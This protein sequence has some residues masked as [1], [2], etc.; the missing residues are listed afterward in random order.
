MLKTVEV[1][2]IHKETPGMYVET[3]AYYTADDVRV[4]ISGEEVT[5]FI[6]GHINKEINANER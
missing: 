5:V 6:S 1:R 4:Q 3:R 2:E